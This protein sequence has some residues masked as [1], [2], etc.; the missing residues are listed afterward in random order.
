MLNVTMLSAVMLNV[1]A[2]SFKCGA[3]KCS[4]QI[5]TAHVY[6]I[7]LGRISLRAPTL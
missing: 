4:S 5:G 3:V 1:V 6:N 2:P 7:M